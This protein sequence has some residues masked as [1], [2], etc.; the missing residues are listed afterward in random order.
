M[1]NLM[2]LLLFILVFRTYITGNE[3]FS[4]DVFI[5]IPKYSIL[6]YQNKNYISMKN[7]RSNHNLIEERKKII[8][9]YEIITCH[10]KKYFYDMKNDIT[11]T[12]YEIKNYILWNSINIYYKIGKYCE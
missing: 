7:F 9:E 10:Q 5:Q 4:D 8:K 3:Q 2:V 11:I 12:N 1:I 6:K